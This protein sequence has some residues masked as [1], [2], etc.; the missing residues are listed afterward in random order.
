MATQ[1]AYSIDMEDGKMVVR[2]ENGVL[3]RDG[4]SRFLDYLLLESLREKSALTDDE[5][6]QL[7]DEI[8]QGAWERV[9]H[10]FEPGA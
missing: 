7:A 2:V 3:S 5:A 8:Q 4:V 9:R 1:P 10:L 6:A